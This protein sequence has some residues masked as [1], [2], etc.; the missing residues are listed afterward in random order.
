MCMCVCIYVCIKTQSL[1]FKRH[2]DSRLEQEALF[3]WSVSTTITNL[4]QHYHMRKRTN[5]T[6][7]VCS[8]AF[9]FSALPTAELSHLCPA[10]KQFF[11][12]L[13]KFQAIQ[14]GCLPALYWKYI[15]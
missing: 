13:S 6:I 15:K 5:E 10:K 12:W 7:S 14:A 9:W 2:K 1:N 8:W 11:N 3:I 4:L